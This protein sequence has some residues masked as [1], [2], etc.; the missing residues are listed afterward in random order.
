MGEGAYVQKANK[1]PKPRGRAHL[2]ELRPREMLCALGA[3][4]MGMLCRALAPWTP[5][6]SAGRGGDPP[7]TMD[8]LGEGAP[9]W[10][11]RGATVLCA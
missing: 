2:L 11:S 9:G 10:E 8:P 5:G 4:G 7:S 6:W 1:E 3:W